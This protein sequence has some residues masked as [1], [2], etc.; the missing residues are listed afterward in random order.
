MKLAEALALRADAQKR[1]AQLQARATAAARYQEGE[2]P[3]EDAAA[4]LADGRELTD[5]IES[6]IRRINRTNAGSC[7]PSCG[8]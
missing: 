3:P 7:A 2:E 8:S 1:L 5:E 6:L 4:L